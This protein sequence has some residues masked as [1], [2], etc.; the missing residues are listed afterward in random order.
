M[1]IINV[2][3]SIT[4]VSYTKNIFRVFNITSIAVILFLSSCERYQINPFSSENDKIDYDNTIPFSKEQINRSLKNLT[5]DLAMI[6]ENTLVKQLLKEEINKQFDG[7]YD[8]LL[9]DI[10]DHYCPTKI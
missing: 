7:D 1:K 4:M 6:I 3:K 2:F 9:K 5:V 10:K 8:V